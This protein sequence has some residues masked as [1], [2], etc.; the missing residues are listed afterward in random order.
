MSFFDG[1]QQVSES[2]LLVSQ[3]LTDEHNEFL[4]GNA[5]KE[6]DRGTQ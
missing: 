5:V 4:V 2:E 6:S 1:L 3:S